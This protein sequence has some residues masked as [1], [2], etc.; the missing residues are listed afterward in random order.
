VI[1]SGDWR[2]GDGTA[3]RRGPFTDC[4]ILGRGY[5]TQ[6]ID[7]HCHVYNTNGVLWVYVRDTTTGVAGWA[8]GDTIFGGTQT[9]SCY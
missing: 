3:I 1:H 4:D 8:R 9:G 7:V 6:G 2:F 5:R